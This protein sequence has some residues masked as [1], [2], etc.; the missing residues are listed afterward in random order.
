RDPRRWHPRR[1]PIFAPSPPP[2]PPPPAAAPA[3]VARAAPRRHRPPQRRP[4]RHLRRHR[5][6]YSK[7]N[8]HPLAAFVSI[9]TIGY[10]LGYRQVPGRRLACEVV[11][12]R[13]GEAAPRAR[14]SE[15][16]V[17][18]G[19]LDTQDTGSVAEPLPAA[20]HA[21]LRAHVHP[22]F[23]WRA[24]QP[25]RFDVA[26]LRLARP[27]ALRAHVLPAC[28]PRPGQAFKGRMGVV[29]GWGKTHTGF[30]KQ[31]TN[32]LHK[33]AVP[34]LSDAECLAWHRRKRIA[35]EL[36]P[37]I[38]RINKE[39]FNARGDSGGPLVVMSEGRWTLAGITSAG[40]GCGVDHQP[41]IYHAVSHTV[42]WIA[43]HLHAAG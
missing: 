43:A 29:A 32:I 24:A 12:S 7:K 35:L 22:R 19:E 41:G 20:A 11:R 9:T 37:E 15:I 27:A 8:L 13:A 18:L 21:V 23:Q 3:A 42:K 14:A 5:S 34:I 1:C 10:R 6:K 30:G 33:A 28:L 4:P 16:T 2:P 40:F 26:L 39:I 38:E 17:L 31:G 25:D 36:H